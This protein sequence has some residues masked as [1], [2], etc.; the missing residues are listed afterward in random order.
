MT[1][2]TTVPTVGHLIAGETTT[3]DSFRDHRDPGRL[4][5]VVA[6]IAVGT[7]ADVGPEP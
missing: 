6:R 4:S 5:E 7:P 2:S 1:T 3:G